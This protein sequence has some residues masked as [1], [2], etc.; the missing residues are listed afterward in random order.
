MHKMQTLV[1]WGQWYQQLSVLYDILTTIGIIAKELHFYVCMYVTYNCK[2]V[3]CVQCWPA[4]HCV[5]DDSQHRPSHSSRLAFLHECTAPAQN[6]KNMLKNTISDFWTNW[7]LCDTSWMILTRLLNRL[8][9]DA[10]NEKGKQL[11]TLKGNGH[12]TF[13]NST[14][15]SRLKKTK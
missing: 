10:F 2:T 8:L 3:T 13:K 14:V 9:P 6:Y 7:W 11:W 15:R 12:G 1:T 4:G 5:W